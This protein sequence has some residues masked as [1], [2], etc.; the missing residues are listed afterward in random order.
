MPSKGTEDIVKQI[1]GM[2]VKDLADLVKTLEAEFGVSAAMPVAAAPVAGAAAGA[3]APAEEKTEY[4]VTLKDAGPEKIKVIKAL[5]ALIN[6]LSLTEAKEKAE[7]APTVIAE[8]APKEEAEKMK[9]MLEEAGAKVEL[10]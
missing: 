4:K 8:A 5:R 9:K 1:S 7:S 3:A 6:G 10:A 2:S